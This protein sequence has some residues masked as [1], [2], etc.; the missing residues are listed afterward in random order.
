MEL[1]TDVPRVIEDIEYLMAEGK[2]LEVEFPQQKFM[3]V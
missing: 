2:K 3:K 1:L